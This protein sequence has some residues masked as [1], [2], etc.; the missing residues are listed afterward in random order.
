MKRML[1]ALIVVAVM[2]SGAFAQAAIQHKFAKFI[3]NSNGEFGDYSDITDTV[4]FGTA[5]FLPT[6]EAPDGYVHY[7][8]WSIFTAGTD[9]IYVVTGSIPFGNKNVLGADTLNITWLDSTKVLAAGKIDVWPSLVGK[10][11]ATLITRIKKLGT[12]TGSKAR[13]FVIEAR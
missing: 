2:V 5:K 4:A 1:L 3:V 11:S 9:S 12:T 10:Q 13:R 7:S 6:F 8:F